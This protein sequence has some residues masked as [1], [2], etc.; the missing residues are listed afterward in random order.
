MTESAIFTF[1][2][3][4]IALLIT[5]LVLPFL[6][7]MAGKALVLDT[8]LVAD[9]LALFT[10]AILLITLLTGSYPA[11][12]LS[13]FSAI[14]VLKSRLI[15]GVGNATFRQTLVVLQ[16]AVSISILVATIVILNQLNF[17]QTKDLGY[18]RAQVL[19]IEVQGESTPTQKETF[20]QQIQSLSFVKSVSLAALLPGQGM[21]QNKL[22]ESYVPKGKGLGY[23]FNIIDKDFLKTM[24]I[25]LVEGA[26]FNETHKAAQNLFLVNKEMVAFLEWKDGAVGK[27]IGYY[28]Y[29]YMPDG[30]YKE[31]PV[32]G[33]VIGVIEDYHQANLKTKMMPMLLQ[34]SSGFENIFAIKLESDKIQIAVNELAK[35]WKTNFPDKPFEYIFLDEN[36]NQTYQ[37]EAHIA[38]AFG[39]FTSLAIFISCLGLFGLAAF[40]AEQRVKEIGIRKVLGASV[41]QIITLLSKDFLKLVLIAFV[42]ASPVAYYFMDKWL[43][44]FAYRI[45]ISWWIFALAGL[46]AITI[47]LLTV[48]WQSIKAALMNPVK[49]LRSE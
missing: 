44:D 22:V 14:E 49:S 13:S 7:Q 28:S 2:G 20:K 3:T 46:S 23:V 6:N 25:K 48:S 12:I 19:S 41:L 1:L 36:F 11:F 31:V 33:Q 34:V 27:E 35:L 16:F 10:G 17:I 45:T 21:F 38:T 40:T 43:A 8:L 39:I 24:N 9:K 47:A 30:S 32:R 15:R 37:R 5:P 4:L 42:I 18:S 29:Q 26:N